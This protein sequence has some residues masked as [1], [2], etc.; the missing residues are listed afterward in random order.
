MLLNFFLI[1]LEKT[2][3]KGKEASIVFVD[4]EK[5]FDNVE[6]SEIF[7]ILKSLGKEYK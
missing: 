6:W 4:A 5:I 3:K 7:E 2:G 1:T